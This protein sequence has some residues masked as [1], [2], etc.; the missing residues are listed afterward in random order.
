MTI[1][2]SQWTI[3]IST[4]PFGYIRVEGLANNV[5]DAIE[6]L[7][8][9][10]LHFVPTEKEFNKAKNNFS[11]SA[12]MSHGNKA[13]KLFSQKWSNILYK[14][15]KYIPSSKEVNYDN[16]LKFG[17]DYFN[18]GNMIISVVSPLMP[19][20]VNEYF[21]NF[22][23][24]QGSELFSG[25]GYT[26]ELKDI[27]SSITVDTTGGGEQAYLYYGYQKIISKNEKPVL[28]S[29]ITAAER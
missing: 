17:K 13:K 15:Q 2:T 10:M 19:D 21:S 28:K 11:Y 1:P 24:K 29:I 8:N 16:F 23:S 5:Q 6:F 18:P 4:R 9:Q 3:F 12:M 22:S 14:P 20:T 7:N 26:R 25:L 27:K